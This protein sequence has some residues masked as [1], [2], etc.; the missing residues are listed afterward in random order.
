ML[1][2]QCTCVTDY[3]K[4]YE[5]K[6]ERT[7]KKF[8]TKSVIQLCVIPGH[9]LFLALTCKSVGVVIHS[10]CSKNNQ[11]APDPNFQVWYI[12]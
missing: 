5:A 1:S 8:T 10:M 9:G 11:T 6:L 12:I 7:L 3:D 2:L 4:P